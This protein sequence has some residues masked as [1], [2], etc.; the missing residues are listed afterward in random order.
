M[1]A[2]TATQDLDRQA[3]LGGRLR[4]ALL[5]GV[6]VRALSLGT[7]ATLMVLVA[8]GV[9]QAQ[10]KAPNPTALGPPT[11]D[12][13]PYVL[14]AGFRRIPTDLRDHGKP[15][16]LF[17]GTLADDSSASV[18]WP[19][20]KALAQFGT[21]TNVKPLGQS[22]PSPA[23]FLGPGG[24]AQYP[25]PDS[26]SR[27]PCGPPTFDLLHATY[28]SRYVS[29]SEKDLLDESLHVYVNRLSPVERTLYARYARVHWYSNEKDNI[30]A[31]VNG[32]FAYIAGNETRRLPLFLI[33]DELQTGV[34]NTGWGDFALEWPTGVPT[35]SR[36]TIPFASFDAVRSGLVHNAMPNP[37][38]SAVYATSLLFH[39]NIDTN[40]FT[41][42]ICHVD[43]MQPR[44]V[45]GRAVIQTIVKHF[46]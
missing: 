4:R 35:L 13:A 33:G 36:T 29:F 11:N 2:R 34:L 6:K 32:Y 21:F 45:C 22:C 19:I 20:V 9:T 27:E 5:H 31:S 25:I 42:A 46:K 7:L 28:H 14:T 23:S 24:N 40:V 37:P 41:A 15:E 43:G 38:N 17:M 44:S 39:V 8:A 12:L 3:H 10:P 16:F 26:G 1:A 18:R 30:F